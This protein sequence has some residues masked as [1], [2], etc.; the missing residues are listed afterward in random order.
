[1]FK[2]ELFRN[3]KVEALMLILDSRM[4]CCV[5]LIIEEHECLN[6]FSFEAL[7]WYKVLKKSFCIVTL[8]NNNIW[9]NSSTRM[10]CLR[11]YN[12]LNFCSRV[13]KGNLQK[14]EDDFSTELFDEWIS[15]SC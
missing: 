5:T 1:M 8:H 9:Y 11:K 10:T 15:G 13:L 6:Y 2:F 4:G 12:L 7:L 14:M 3:F